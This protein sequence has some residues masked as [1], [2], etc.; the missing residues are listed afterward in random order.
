MTGRELMEWIIENKV[1]ECPVI[2]VD[3]ENRY[4]EVQGVWEG[5]SEDGAIMIST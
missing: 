2:V 1:E 5:E 4:L 3:P